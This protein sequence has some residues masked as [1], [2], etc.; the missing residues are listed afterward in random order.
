MELTADSLEKLNRKRAQDVHYFYH[1]AAQ[2]VN[3]HNQ[4]NL[5]ES[6]FLRMLEYGANKDKYW[7]V[8]HMILQL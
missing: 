7:T 6:P 3:E 2:D 1:I 5:T 4:K 8:N